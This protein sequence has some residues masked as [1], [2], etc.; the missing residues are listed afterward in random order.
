MASLIAI[1][2]QQKKRDTLRLVQS[3]RSCNVLQPEKYSAVNWNY[4]MNVFKCSI[5]NP[6]NETQKRIIVWL[7]FEQKIEYKGKNW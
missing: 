2:E 7:K 3:T 1:I 6:L 4:F 5:W